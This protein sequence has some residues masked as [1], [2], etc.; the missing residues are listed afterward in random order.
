MRYQV[1]VLRENEKK[2]VAQFYD[3]N[4]RMKGHDLSFFQFDDSQIRMRIEN[5]LSELKIPFAQVE[6]AGDKI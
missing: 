3:N 6:W 5:K 2:V 4:Q 1:L